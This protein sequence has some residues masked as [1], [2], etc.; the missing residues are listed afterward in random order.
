[1][2]RMR[3]NEADIDGTMTFAALMQV[4]ARFQSSFVCLTRPCGGH[5]IRLNMVCPR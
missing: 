5:N 4:T 1:M 3:P 2:T